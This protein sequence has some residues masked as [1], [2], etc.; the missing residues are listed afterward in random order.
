MGIQ[1]Y[2]RSSSTR[3]LLHS[4]RDPRFYSVR[5]VFRITSTH[6]RQGQA[7]LRSRSPHRLV[8][9]RLHPRLP[10]SNAAPLNDLQALGN[11]RKRQIVASFSSFAAFCHAPLSSYIPLIGGSCRG[12]STKPASGVRG[13][14]VFLPLPMLHSIIL[15]LAA[16]STA[17]NTAAEFL[18]IRLPL[19]AI[20]VDDIVVIKAEI[21]RVERSARPHP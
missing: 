1:I 11:L 18:Q 21:E 17:A 10:G 14:P 7:A 13:S 6:L 3:H 2:L 5:Q 16:P 15:A 12:W 9:H 19:Q 4:L 8:Q 20:H